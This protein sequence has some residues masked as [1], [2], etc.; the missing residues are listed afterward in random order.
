MTVCETSTLAKNYLKDRLPNRHQVVV[1]LGDALQLRERM[2]SFRLGDGG[3]QR[4]AVCQQKLLPRSGAA[5]PA[6]A[7]RSRPRRVGPS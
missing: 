3:E 1:F 4:A 2:H 6:G 7:A 5:A